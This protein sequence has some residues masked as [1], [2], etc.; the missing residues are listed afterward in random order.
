M[1]FASW[2]HLE[3]LVTPDYCAFQVPIERYGL[4]IV[5]ARTVQAAH[6][7]GVT[8]LPWTIDSDEDLEI[9]RRTGCDGINTN[10]PSKMEKLRAEW[11]T[12]P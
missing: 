8:V 9:C 4:P 1:V 5:T 2:L 3:G 10:L 11:P 6:N 12:L 7:R